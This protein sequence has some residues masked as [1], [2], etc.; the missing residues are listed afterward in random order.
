MYA[1]NMLTY[2]LFSV[3]PKLTEFSGCIKPRYFLLELVDSTL[4]MLCPIGERLDLYRKLGEHV[5][6]VL[7]EAAQLKDDVTE[8]VIGHAF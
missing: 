3:I 8:R 6:R 4:E 7:A 2:S 1:L 5:L